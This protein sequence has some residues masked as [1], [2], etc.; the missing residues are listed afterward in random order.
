MA[1]AA[2]E[3]ELGAAFGGLGFSM[4]GSKDLA[5]GRIAGRH[6]D[7][8]SAGV[9]L[10]A[11]AMNLA[12]HLACSR[13]YAGVLNVGIA[14]SYDLTRLG[15]GAVAVAVFE[16]WPEYGLMTDDGV[17]AE[18][19][20]FPVFSREGLAV[21]NRM[22]LDPESAAARMGLELGPELVSAGFCSVS[23]IAATAEDAARKGFLQN[24]LAEN[25]EGFALA[26]VCAKFHLPFL[27]VRS[28]SN[29]AGTREKRFWNI[30]LAFKSL[31]AGVAGMF[32]P[33][34]PGY[35]ENRNM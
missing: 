6:V 21:W 27:E 34:M 25:M 4:P 28:I 26:L 18:K 14:G 15:L 7:F 11:S 20:G 19:L 13:D 3:K 16:S 10:V 23:T 5:S 9:G 30:G 32:G 29:L 24:A 8:L 35:L 31:A 33:S 17:S 22:E 1:V 2:T 12:A